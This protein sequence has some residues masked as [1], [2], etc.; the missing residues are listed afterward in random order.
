M[1]SDAKVEVEDM[2]GVKTQLNGILPTV[3]SILL[4]SYC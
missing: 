2:K 3:Q 4:A 1:L